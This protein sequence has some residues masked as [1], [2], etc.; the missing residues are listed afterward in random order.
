MANEYVL[1]YTHMSTELMMMLVTGVMA[2]R[3]VQ[4]V[5]G[6]KEL[7]FAWVSQNGLHGVR[8]SLT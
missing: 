8:Y 1:R 5:N 4:Q 3:F 6:R 7:V 2:V